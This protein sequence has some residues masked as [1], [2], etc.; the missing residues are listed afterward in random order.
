VR[1]L[2]LSDLHLELS[3]LELPQELQFDV[4]LLAGDIVN[5][6]R[7]LA[8]WVAAS[9]VLR[10]ARAVLAVSG[11]HEYYDAV[12]QHEAAAMQ[13]TAR[14]LST[15][16]LH[17]LDAAQVVIDGVRFLGCTLWTD[18]AL[19][20]DTPQGPR[21]DVARGIAA[22]QRMMVD[23]R[24][25]AWLDDGGSPPRRL[26]PHDTLRLH[27]Q[28]RAWLQQRLAEPFD[29]PT[30]VLTHHGPHRRSLAPRF[31]ADWVSTAYLSELPESFFEVPRLWLHGHTHTSHDYDVG[32]CRIVCNPRGYQTKAMTQP[33]NV[34]FRPDWVVTV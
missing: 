20:I 27:L 1:L 6:G 23:Y 2:L 12:W 29:G 33:E 7:R 8:D 13:A 17:L 3:N 10:Q 30:V 14:T 31:A 34:A 19:R 9:P 15:P 28:Q 18:F 11:N 25:I 4:A 5:P 22:A 21:S 32:R 26:T 16:P 24:A